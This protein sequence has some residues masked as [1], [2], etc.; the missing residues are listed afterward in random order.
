MRAMTASRLVFGWGNPMRGDDAVGPL[1]IARLRAMFGDD[2]DVELIEDDQLQIEHAVDLAGRS[3]VL[4][5]DA[6][7]SCRAPFEASAVVAADEFGYTTHGL[8]PQAL[9]SVYRSVCATDPPPCTLVAIRGERFGLG[10]APSA[11]ALE[12]L[13]AALR[14]ICGRLARPG[15]AADPAAPVADAREGAE[16]AAARASARTVPAAPSG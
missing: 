12:N 15:G 3:D 8:S 11:Q 16:T 7:A 2:S 5:V 1:A 10:E 14:W 13:E 9:A 6:S 4:F